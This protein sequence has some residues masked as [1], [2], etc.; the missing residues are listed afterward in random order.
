[1]IQ[2]LGQLPDKFRPHLLIAGAGS[3][4]DNCR[5]L[6]KTIAPENITFFT[7]WPTEKTSSVYAAANVLILPTQGTQSL[8][9]VPSKLITYMLSARP[10]IAQALSNS[11]LSKIIHETGCGWVV[12]P[13]Q[14]DLLANAIL[15]A[16]RLS[17]EELRQRGQAGRKYALQRLTRSACLPRIIGILEEAV[18][19]RK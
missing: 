9:S 12:E 14:P 10:I 2:A 13:D 6:A 11:D 7:P 15:D 16:M 19:V 17:P 4:L 3:R 1:V 5:T 8:V 18:N